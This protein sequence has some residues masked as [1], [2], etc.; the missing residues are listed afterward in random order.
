[1]VIEPTHTTVEVMVV[2]LSSL[3]SC[4]VAS[5]HD[6]LLARLVTRESTGSIISLVLRG[7]GWRGR[8][9]SIR[10]G[11]LSER[12]RA[13]TP[14]PHQDGPK[15]PLWLNV[16]N[17]VVMASLCN[18]TSVA[19]TKTLHCNEKPIYMFPGKKL[20]GLS[21]N[22]YI[23][24]S[25][26]DLYIPR[27]GAHIFLPQNRSWEYK[28]LTDTWMWKLGLRPRN[29]PACSV[30]C[31]HVLKPRTFHRTAVCTLMTRKL[32]LILLPNI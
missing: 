15:I 13:C 4:F 19:S 31:L 29:P 6:S 8:R 30:H 20:P 27:I 2:L 21:P 14:N 26:S 3:Y 9:N 25:M 7:S 1:M 12:G 11:R 22:F 16:R 18:L 23:R 28:L 10:G 24:V 5:T 17:E 32:S